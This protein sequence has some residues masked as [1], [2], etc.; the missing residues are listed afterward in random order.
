MAADDEAPS[1]QGAGV[2]PNLRVE[3]MGT[4][5]YL[6]SLRFSDGDGLGLVC[7]GARMD[8]RRSRIVLNAGGGI[9]VQG[10]CELSIEN[11][12]VGGTIDTDALEVQSG[13]ASVLYS[14]LAASARIAENPA[15][16]RCDGAATVSVRNSILVG[17]STEPE[18]QCG[19]STVSYSASEG[20]LGGPGN[21]VVGE[22]D[23]GWFSDFVSGDFLLSSSGGIAFEG[24]AR[25]EDGDPTTDIDGTTRPEIT[26]TMDH[27]GADVP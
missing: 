9:L 15:A 18:V 7:N 26:G 6:E 11:S 22:F 16:V 12:F 8:V 2:E 1:L 4:T 5:A 14:T 13:T 21:T 17:A 25:W 24:V 3:G 23:A 19:G 27:A 10:S 20:A